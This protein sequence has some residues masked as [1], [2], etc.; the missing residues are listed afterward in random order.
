MQIKAAT[1]SRSRLW[2]SFEVGVMS[3]WESREKE[4]QNG[5]TSR[6]GPPFSW[7]RK[8]GARNRD[9]FSASVNPSPTSDWSEARIVKNQGQQSRTMHARGPSF[10][11]VTLQR[12]A[13]GLGLLR[14]IHEAQ[15]PS[16]RETE[17]SIH[18]IFANG[19]H[20]HPAKPAI[21]QIAPSVAQE[22]GDGSE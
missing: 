1:N 21:S 5:G 7:P 20:S 2:F 8:L 9:H 10:G 22:F 14:Q 12:K 19:P 3:N 18:P 4:F 17:N 16:H 11:E 6:S 15:L 13:R